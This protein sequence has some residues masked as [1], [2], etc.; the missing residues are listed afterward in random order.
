MLRP[1]FE[2]E[3]VAFGYGTNMHNMLN[4]IHSSYIAKKHIPDDEEINKVLDRVFK[5]R[6][7]TQAIADKMKKS[8]FKIVRNY[9]RLHRNDFNKILETENKF[10]FVLNDALISGQID[11]L[12]RI[13]E[14][15]NL[16]EVEII[17]F[18]MDRNDSIYQGDYDKQLR[19]YAIACLESL[20]SGRKE[21]MFTILIA[22]PE[23]TWILHRRNSMRSKMKSVIK[24]LQ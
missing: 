19:F 5:V 16:T 17:D 22:T 15:G 14:S 4:I 8:V 24:S 20:V 13:D 10:E 2:P 1:G 21:H 12:K 9:V 6:Y 23:A 3:I 11:L 7:A 18:K